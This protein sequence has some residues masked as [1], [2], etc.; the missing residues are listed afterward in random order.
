MKLSGL[1]LLLFGLLI[2][3]M[4]FAQKGYLRGNIQDG[5]FGGPLI[6]ATVIVV[7]QPGIGATTDFD[8]N[9]SLALDPGTYTVKISFISFTTV[10]F[11]EVVIK[12]GETTVINGTLMPESQQLVEIEVT[13]TVKRNTDAGLLIKMRNSPNVV[14]GIS[15]QSFKRVGDNDLS[16]SIKR[17]TGVT[18]EGGKYVYVRGLGDRY[19][20]TT[21]NGMAIPGLDPDVNAVQIDIFPTAVLENVA[22]YKSFTPNLYG[23]FAGGLIDVETKSFPTEKT[24]SLSVGL[25]YIQNQTFNSDYILYKG[26]NFDWLGFDDGTRKLPFSKTTPIPLYVNSDPELRDLTLSLNPQ[27]AAESRTALPGG[28]FTFNHG[29]QI[30]KENGQNFGYNF[31]FNYNNSYRFYDRFQQNYAR[32]NGTSSVYELVQNE[33]IKGVIGRNEVQWSGLLSGAYKLGTNSYEAMLLHS[34]SGES[35]A[36]QRISSQ[37]EQNTAT[38]AENILTYTQ[39]SLSTLIFSGS[40]IKGKTQI[41]WSN[42]ATYSRVYDPDFRTASLSI[43]PS[44]DPLDPDGQDTLLGTGDGSKLE[45]LWRD[46]NEFNENARV[47]FTIPLGTEKNFSLKT[48]A[49]ALLKWRSFQTLE[50][51]LDRVDKSPMNGDPNWFLQP[52]NVYSAD[53]VGRNYTRVEGFAIDGSGVQPSNNFDARQNVYGAY[54][55]AEQSFK[56]VLKLIYGVRAEMTQMYYTGQN[57]NGSLVFNDDKTL[58]ELNILPSLSGVYT[59]NKD[60]NL[61]ASAS[62]TIARPSFKE[63]SVA[64]IYDPITK[65]TFIGNIE[66]E[67]TKVNNYDLRWEWFL[68]PAELLSLAGFYKTFDGHIEMVPNEANPDEYKPRNSGQALVYGVELELRK[69][70]LSAENFLKHIF[71]GGNVTLVQSQVDLKSVITSNDGSTEYE[72]RENNL[73]DG[74]TLTQYRAMA[75]QSPYAVNAN[76]SY[77]VLEKGYSFSLAYSVKGEQLSLVGSGLNPDIY[78]IPFNSLDFNANYSFGK[79]KKHQMGLRIENLLDDDRTLVYRSFGIDDMVFNQFHP[80]RAFRIKYTYNF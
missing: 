35:S 37:T 12:S 33:G 69:K 44:S 3:S 42:A 79:D 27:M 80:G 68:S 45:R 1:R 46:L 30:T 11:S 53:A 61:R 19:T 55:M 78:L 39:R 8:G 7:E 49:N 32:K 40:H 43:R 16:Q 74:E 52:E 23:D 70:F 73:R 76:L 48:G 38:L 54:I 64:Q 71:V 57:Q 34:Q 21:L 63:K 36:S 24:T 14:D 51:K 22:V 13:A 50:Y 60:M 41:Q 77:E 10:T 31:V 4:G 5:D 9:Y 18:V 66:L 26:G 59:L 67:Q 15:S 6:G 62:R 25:Q 58:D 20:K 65:L 2:T 47:D 72:L 29:N 28:R 17:V 75:G 56:K